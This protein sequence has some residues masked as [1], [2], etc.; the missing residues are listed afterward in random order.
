M[1]RECGRKAGNDDPWDFGTSSQLPVLKFGRHNANDQRKP[2]LA[3]VT[4]LT[5]FNHGGDGKRVRLSWT[6]VTGATGYAGR[7]KSGNQTYGPERQVAAAPGATELVVTGLTTNTAYTFIVFATR[8]NAAN[9]PD[10]S[11]VSHTPVAGDYDGGRRRTNRSRRPSHAQRHT[12]GLGRQR[13]GVIRQ[14]YELLHR[15]P[16]RQ[17]GDGLPQ[18]RLHSYELVNDIRIS[19]DW[20][21]LV[22]TVT[23]H[24]LGADWMTGTPFDATFEGNDYTI[25]NLNQTLFGQVGYHAELK[26]WDQY[27]PGE[28]NREV[29]LVKT[30]GTAVVRNLKLDMSIDKTTAKANL[31]GGFDRQ[32][33]CGFDLN[34]RD[35]DLAPV[36]NANFGGVAGVL[37]VGEIRNV[38]VT[39]SIKVTTD[40][41]Y[42]VNVGGI[43]G[44]IHGGLVENSQSDA[45]IT[46]V[47]KSTKTGAEYECYRVGGIAGSLEWGAITASRS[48]GAIRRDGNSGGNLPQGK[49][50]LLAGGIAGGLI[51]PFGYQA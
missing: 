14:R 20:T 12:L 7:W 38:L 34:L 40:F 28:Y 11:E 26:D 29:R 31:H 39:G 46:I 16:Q 3:Q 18:Y 23:S 22:V 45:D 19:G 44:V 30:P 51:Q 5:A 1:G 37:G 41:E 33:S 17:R 9:G 8:D 6:A 25:S 32:Q 4:A 15:L 48:R 36:I 2:A 21:P 35:G 10:S 47:H 42:D 49:I 24:P 13:N 50:I 43:V 27:T